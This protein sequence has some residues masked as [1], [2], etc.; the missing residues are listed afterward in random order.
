[1]YEQQIKEELKNE[2]KNKQRINTKIVRM[3][4][5]KF[6]QLE[7]L[8]NLKQQFQLSDFEVG[9]HIMLNLPFC[10]HKCKVCGKHITY[11]DKYGGWRQ[12]CST[13][14]AAKDPDKLKATRATVKD[15]Y[16][17][18]WISKA[19]VVKQKTA[20][21]NIKR[22]GVKGTSQCKSVR[23]KQKRT[24]LERYGS[25]SPLA[26]KEVLDKIAKTNT[27]RYGVDNP[28]KSDVFQ[29]KAIDTNIQKY[30]VKCVLQ[31][32]EIQEKV[33]ATNLEKF[34]CENVFQNPD[35]KAKIKDTILERYGVD[36]P[37][38]NPKV[39]AK[40]ESTLI[41]KYGPDYK[42]MLRIKST[43]VLRRKSWELLQYKLAAQIPPQAITPLFDEEQY[44]NTDS[45]IKLPWLCHECN[46][47]FEAVYINGVLPVCRTCHP[48]SYREKQNEVYKYLCSI[49]PEEKIITDTRKVI[50]PK[51]L[52]I[53]LPELK[54]AIEFNGNYWHSE[55]K[56][57]NSNYHLDKT[58]ACEQQGIHLI[59]I[60]EH[61]WD[62]TIT[63]TIIKQRLANCIVKGNY[64]YARKCEV[65]L[66]EEFKVVEAFLRNNHLQGSITSKVNLG[67]YYDNDL[68]AVM[69]FGKPRFNKQYEW[70]L[71]R[72]C[73]NMRVIGGASKLLKYFERNYNPTSLISY[74]NR[75]W[76]MLGDDVVYKKLGMELIGESK[77]NYLYAKEGEQPK[78]RYQCQK[79]KLKDLLGE[80]NFNPDLSESENMYLNGWVKIF[81]C[82]NLVYK[83]NY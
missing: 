9:K 83:K 58:K 54:L 7:L 24:C 19:E 12:C 50:A 52:D 27:E 56:I 80:D 43:E 13:A 75:D 32:P 62:N 16:G 35:I 81:D 33:K 18:D 40:V 63:Q 73:S 36:H 78:T 45:D 29:Q 51:K 6:E 82:G 57:H 42:D 8:E 14:C 72:F 79:H 46:Q 71:L 61:L 69:T 28:F 67:L 10:I 15:K 53:Y 68:V 77:P 39:K 4:F 37:L 3:L 23:D 55:D 5:G 22:Y 17:V 1:M 49:Y 2:F 64:V 74:A 59:H 44:I 66:I 70:E 38:K 65:R 20:E 21:T 25:T 60:W 11:N 26:N 41:A 34:G 48:F 76:S 30:G 31:A 47:E